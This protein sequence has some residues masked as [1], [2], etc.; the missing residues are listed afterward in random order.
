MKKVLAALTTA[1]IPVLISVL[2]ILVLLSPIFMNLEY[3]WEIWTYVD[4]AFFF[5][6]GKVFDRQD[7]LNFEDLHYGYGGGVRLRAPGFIMF[8]MDLAHSEEG[9]KLHIGGGPSF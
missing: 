6:A 4:L 7:E 2:S 3:R 1:A 8:N 5:D 9:W